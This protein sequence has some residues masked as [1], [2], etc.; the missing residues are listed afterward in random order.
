MVDSIEKEHTIQFLVKQGF[1]IGCGICAS[2]CPKTALTIVECRETGTYMPRLDDSK[3][4]KCGL[5]L[6]ICPGTESDFS[7]LNLISFNQKPENPFV[8]NYFKCYSGYATDQNIRCKSSSGGLIPA[9]ATFALEA[10]IADG[11]LTTRA[12]A[13]RP[14]RPRS[15]IARTR[16]EVM[17][18]VGSKYCPVSANSALDE[19]LKTRGRYIMVG[20]PCHIL[21]LRKAQ[22]LNRDLKNR[23]LLVF[24]LVCNHTPT[25]HATDFLLN[26][27]KIPIE[28]IARLDYRS[29]GWPGY[30]RIVMNDCSKQF[31]PFNSS[32]YWGY[33]FQKFFWS[34]RCIICND[35]LCQLADIIFMDAWLPVFSSDKIGLSL[36]VT[37]SKKGDEFVSKAIENGVVKLQP[38]PIGDVLK[39]QNV[40]AIIHKVVAR[41]HVMKYNSKEF[42]TSSALP[43]RLLQT[44]SIIDKLDA[45][46]LISTNKLCKKDSKLLYLIVECHVKLW[47]LARSA[48]KK[49]SKT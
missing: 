10:G 40:P 23:I 34:K 15:F 33:V 1:C 24:G 16:A 13:Q 4:N 9:L 5:C 21:G 8:G 37:R 3:C 25:F 28:K 19:I 30:M 29:S 42:S 35:K 6:R 48:K 38:I 20:L 32:Y 22:V 47:D 2:I 49:I 18:A 11:I 39:S 12:N 26:K 27:F 36:V 44:Q 41:R 43:E 17:S 31:I 46:H 14:L 45:F 7:K